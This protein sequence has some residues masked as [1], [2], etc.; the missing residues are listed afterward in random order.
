MAKFKVE[1]T[2]VY[3]VEKSITIEVEAE[4]REAVADMLDAGDYEAPCSSLSGWQDHWN[5]M[6]E[7]AELCHG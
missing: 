1:I 6:N 7:E 3:R 5:L 2:Q 4:S